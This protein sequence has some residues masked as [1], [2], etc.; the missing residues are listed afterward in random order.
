MQTRC[1]GLGIFAEDTRAFF[2]DLHHARITLI[3]GFKHHRGEHRDVHFVRRLHPAHEFIQVVQGQRVQDFC[4]EA[5]LTAVQIVFAQDQTK[6]LNGK[7]ITAASVAQDVSPPAGSFYSLTPA[8]SDRRTAS[9]VDDNS[10]SMIERR[11]EAGV[12]VAARNDF[13]IWPDLETDFLER[14]AIFLCGATG[15]ENSGAIN[16]L[17]QL[18]KNHAQTLGRREAKFRWGQFSLVNH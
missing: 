14:T 4:G 9:S 3:R 15:K 1:D 10:V 6:R 18:R 17:W 5:D 2:N 8:S 16:L 7:K 12:A 13:S 11:C